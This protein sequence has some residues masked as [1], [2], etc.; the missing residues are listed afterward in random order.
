MKNSS[1]KNNIIKNSKQ[2]VKLTG[3]AASPGITIGKVFTLTGD[4]VKVEERNIPPEQVSHEIQKFSKAI[5]VTRK[6]LTNIQKQAKKKM[7]KEGER[8]FDAHQ[9]LLEDNVINEETISKIQHDCKNAD[10]VYYQVMQ[11]FQ[12]SLEQVDNEYFLGRVA[13]IR[14]VKRRLIRNIQGKEPHY[15]NGLTNLQATT[16]EYSNE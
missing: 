13:D 12:N 2:M 5:V 7:G 1:N 10:F 16:W 14:D 3:I 11:K 15:L 4:V 9:L 6:E 8:I